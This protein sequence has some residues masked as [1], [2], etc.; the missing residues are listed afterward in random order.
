MTN[1]HDV[2]M[3]NLCTR[4]RR[5]WFEEEDGRKVQ[6][7]DFA[8]VQQESST[9]YSPRHYTHTQRHVHSRDLTLAQHQMCR[10]VILSSCIAAASA[11]TNHVPARWSSGHLPACATSV[12]ADSRAG[13]ALKMQLE[14]KSPVNIFEGMD[15]DGQ[16]V[17]TSAFLKESEVKHGRL[18]MLAALGWPAAELLH[19][20]IAQASH[21]PNLLSDGS[22]APNLLN[23]GL[24]RIVQ[25]TPFGIFF[26]FFLLGRVFSVETGAL[27]PRNNFLSKD[28]KEMY[29]YDLGFDPLGFYVKS[30]PEQ[31][32]VMSEKELNNGRLAMIAVSLYPLIEF[33][34]KQPIVQMAVDSE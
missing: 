16:D 24:D 25:G 19:P 2:P 21:F 3:S 32:K 18:A 10:A 8:K 5:S 7:K 29:P 30:S 14:A 11:F 31:R 26:V 34:S 27:R 17:K 13:S 4:I 33:V 1:V 22:Q 9:T 23:G 28:P 12:R 20:F 6:S 15:K